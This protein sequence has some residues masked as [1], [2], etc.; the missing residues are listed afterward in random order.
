[1]WSFLDLWGGG[2]GGGCRREAARLLVLA[3]SADDVDRRHS[4]TWVHCVRA[5]RRDCL[6]NLSTL[7]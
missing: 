6:I 5:R 1:V 2:G 4:V 3:P 7:C